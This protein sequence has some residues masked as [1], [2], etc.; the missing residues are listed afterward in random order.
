[1]LWYSHIRNYSAI[2]IFTNGC[3]KKKIVLCKKN[4]KEYVNK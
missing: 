1:M 3:I 4:K 2:N